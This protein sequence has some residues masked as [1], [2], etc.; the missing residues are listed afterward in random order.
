ME[1]VER[2]NLTKE[3]QVTWAQPEIGKKCIDCKHM[4]LSPMPSQHRKHI[5]ALVKA[6]TGKVGILYDG[7]RAIA[8]SE[9][10]GLDTSVG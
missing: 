4:L 6:H 10:E 3:G 8:C 2:M 5:C 7:N 9:F 1:L